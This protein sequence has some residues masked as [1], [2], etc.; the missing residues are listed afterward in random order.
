MLIIAV[1]ALTAEWLIGQLEHR[2]LAWR[3]AELH[4]RGRRPSDPPA[5]LPPS[6]LSYPRFSTEFSPPNETGVPMSDSFSRRDWQQRATAPLPWR[7]ARRSASARAAAAGAAASGVQRALPTVTLMVG[8]IDKQIYLPYQLAQGLGYY[9]KYGVNVELS[10]EQAGGVG[11]E[12]AMASGQVNMAGA[13]YMHTIDFQK[14]ARTS[15]GVVQLSGAPGERTC[16]PTGPT[17][18]RPPTGRARPSASPT[19]VR[20]PTTSPSTWP[21]GTT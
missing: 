11:A 21:P 9:Q 2:L 5:R 6:V 10:T 19:S 20:A 4:D 16:A 3:P 8:G 12:D 7:P 14:R 1:I 18:T 13:W 17:S 15:I